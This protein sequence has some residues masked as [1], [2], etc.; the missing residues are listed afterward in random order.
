MKNASNDLSVNSYFCGFFFFYITELQTRGKKTGFS[1][2][3]FYFT[4]VKLAVL[5][6]ILY[7]VVR[8]QIITD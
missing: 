5:I 1:V 3:V 4:V 8:V 2:I 6:L 7:D